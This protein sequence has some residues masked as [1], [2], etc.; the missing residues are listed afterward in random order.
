MT[1]I[2]IHLRIQEARALYRVVAPNG[3]GKLRKGWLKRAAL[4]LAYGL[5]PYGIKGKDEL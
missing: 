5:D 2:K 3:A 4:K 1:L